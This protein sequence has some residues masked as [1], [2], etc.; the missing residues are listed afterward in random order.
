M[1]RIIV[2]GEVVSFLCYQNVD[3]KHFLFIVGGIFV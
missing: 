1:I 3:F 2:V